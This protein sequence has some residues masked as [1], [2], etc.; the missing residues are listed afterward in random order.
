VT[1]QVVSER[2]IL[3]VV[4]PMV[5]SAQRR[6]WVTAPWVTNQAASLFFDQLTARVD[7]D[8]LDVRVVY[9]LKGADD[10]SIS[11]L[12]ALDRL[13]AAGC[14]VRYSNRLHAKVV[15]V[16][17]DQAIVSSSNLTATA[18]YSVSSGRWQNEE[19]GVHLDREPRIVADLAGEFERIWA[20][21]HEL[22]GTTV[23]IT[24]DES[25]SS[26]V[27]VACIRPPVVGEFVTVGLPAHTVGTVTSVTSYNPTVP[28]EAGATDAILGLRG[29]GG[30][31]QSRVP[32]VETLFSH[33][34]KT[35]AFLMAQT[36]VQSAA[37]YHVAEVAILRNLDEAG[38]FAASVTAAEPGDIVTDAAP[39]LLDELI[40]GTHSHRL[41]VGRLPSN[42]AVRV[43]LDRDRF[44]SLH[45]AVLGMTGAGK[46][47]AVKVMVRR[48]LAEDDNLRVVIVDTHGEYAG[49]G[50][51][52][53]TNRISVRFSPCLLD[54]A[55]VRRAAKPGRS[56]NDVTEEVNAAVEE[57]GA[58]ASIDQVADTLDIAAG[59]AGGKT[60]ARIQRLAT[61]IRATPNLC[62]DLDQATTVEH[63]GGAHVDWSQP[64]LYVL[65]L[66]GMNDAAERIAQTGALGRVL[67]SYAKATQG[68][69]PILLVVDEAQNYAPEQQTG[70]LASA[71]S[72]F[73][74]LFEI[75]TEG[76]K[77]RCGLLVASQRPARVNKDI[78]S[79]CNTQLI[80]RMVSVE[81]LDAVRDCF[82]ESSAALLAALPGY[83]TGTCYAGGVA[84]AMG[85]QVRFPFL[86]TVQT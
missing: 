55:W 25:T 26:L 42:P 85:V 43:A 68:G 38:H 76:R 30:G 10:L 37:T 11:D 28:A 80:F 60:G 86:E 49:A 14:Q 13:S 74:A 7:A 6:V 19:L 69:Q 39:E 41:E 50:L 59:D 54:E 78:L 20:A 8:E 5:A 65:D 72:S 31:R 12:E 52:A 61:A 34:S 24:L 66:L 3:D 56:L 17:D 48:L 71:R 63:E 70:R 79:Q 64:G 81:D 67:L 62:L 32:D 33:P 84:L 75:A 51:A 47:N 44:L 57:L 1:T 46:S 23:G 4:R 9:R 53:T 58:G 82:E 77:F 35:H 73:E 29:G 22:S 16:D 27:R 45:A 21:A 15:V 18:G 83:D 40:S 36:F 2:D